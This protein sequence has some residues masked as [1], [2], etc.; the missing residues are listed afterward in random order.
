MRPTMPL[1]IVFLPFTGAFS[2]AHTSLWK[3]ASPQVGEG[4]YAP[5][6][7]ELAMVLEGSESLEKY[8]TRP[9]CFRRA[10]GLIRTGCAEL[11]THE[12][13]RVRAALSMTLCELATA[14]HLSP[15]MECIPF[16]VGSDGQTWPYTGDPP[17]KCVEALSRSAQ[18]WSSYSGYLREVPQLCFAFRRWNDIDT[19]KDLHRNSTLQSLAL[20]RHLT[21][22]EAAFERGFSDVAALS[23]K[24]QTLFAEMQMSS[25][26]L[27]VASDGISEQIRHSLNEMSRAFIDTMVQTRYDAAEVRSHELTKIETRVENALQDLALA[28]STFAPV[29]HDMLS[30][31]MEQVHSSMELKLRDVNELSARIEHRF[32][33]FENDFVML[34]Y[35]IHLLIGDTQLAGAELGE[36]LR[37][38][39]AAHEKQLEIAK[40]ADDTALALS[41]LVDKARAEIQ[42]LNSTA[43]AMRES[44]LDSTSAG[45]DL[46]TWSWLEAASMYLVKS[47][48]KVDVVSSDLPVLR[49]LFALS[50]VLRWLLSMAFSGLM[51][52]PFLIFHVC[53]SFSG[54]RRARLSCSRRAGLCSPRMTENTT[55]STAPL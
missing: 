17:G 4:E 42:N 24:M 8:A 55:P 21:D 48:W 28:T 45:W 20:L 29:L 36:R 16:Q 1:L 15:P 46:V 13:E 40:V 18:Y 3:K 39:L 25:T 34:Q 49:A 26:A 2:W 6:P 27:G 37:D 41:D 44:L 23:E 14:E 38:S 50:G 9:D 54:L 7:Q 35:G 5:I 47:I 31:S 12:E 30:L 52:S 43:V 22:R 53:V 19:A 32:L 11:E 33:K 51:V 10:A